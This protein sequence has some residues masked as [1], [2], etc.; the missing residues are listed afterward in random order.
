MRTGDLVLS[1]KA[2][3]VNAG[4][5][6]PEAAKI[7]GVSVFKLQTYEMGRKPKKNCDIEDKM[8]EVYHLNK[9]DIFFG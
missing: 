4:Y 6:I 9:G 7:L 5:T 1:P 8:C 2:A 3:R